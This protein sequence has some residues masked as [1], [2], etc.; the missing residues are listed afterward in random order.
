MDMTVSVVTLATHRKEKYSSHYIAE[1]PFPT[2]LNHS[3]KRSMLKSV[4]DLVQTP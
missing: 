2:H 4:T 3:E 1:M